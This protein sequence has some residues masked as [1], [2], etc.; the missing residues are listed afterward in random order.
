MGWRNE[1]VVLAEGKAVVGRTE[2]ESL[3]RAERLRWSWVCRGRWV[4]ASGQPFAS[5]FGGGPAV[6][7]LGR[8]RS[9]QVS[10]GSRDLAVAMLVV[11]LSGTG[12]VKGTWSL[13]MSA[14]FP[15]R[16]WS[17]TM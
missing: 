6:S 5:A 3:G 9:D 12:S 17:L 4:A 8:S 7:G 16:T 14:M 10:D 2:R 13:T 15:S 1:Q 11:G